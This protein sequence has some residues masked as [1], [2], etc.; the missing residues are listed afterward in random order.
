MAYEICFTKAFLQTLFY[1]TIKI[2][3]LIYE[4][5]LHKDSI[6][7]LNTIAN[8]DMNSMEELKVSA[9]ITMAIWVSIFSIATGTMTYT[10]YIGLKLIPVPDFVVLGHTASLF[11]LIF[12]TI[13]LK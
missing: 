6:Y 8:E 1:V 12:S 4:S 7:N 13:I 11:T 10:A 2:I 9:K 3:S 5:N